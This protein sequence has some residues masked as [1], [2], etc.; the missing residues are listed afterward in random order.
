MGIWVHLAVY[1]HDLRSSRRSV[2][3]SGTVSLNADFW[4]LR[5]ADVRRS[6]SLPQSAIAMEHGD[7][8]S[9]RTQPLVCYRGAVCLLAWWKSAH[10]HNGMVQDSACLHDADSHVGDIGTNQIAFMGDYPQ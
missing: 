7:E 1:V 6:S 8:V 5:N 3:G 10:P 9:A 2:S 4:R